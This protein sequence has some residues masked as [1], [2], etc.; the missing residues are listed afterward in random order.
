MNLLWKSSADLYSVTRVPIMLDIPPPVLNP[1]S[2][3]NGEV[4]Y[5]NYYGGGIRP[6]AV[7]SSELAALAD[8]AV[9]HDLRCDSLSLN[10]SKGN[11]TDYNEYH[12][13]QEIFHLI[14]MANCSLNANLSIAYNAT[15]QGEVTSSYSEEVHLA[16]GY[17]GQVDARPFP[18]LFSTYY[19]SPRG[20]RVSDISAVTNYFLEC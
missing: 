9:T 15:G 13:S 6:Y 3:L 20:A 10:S 19:E 11:A 1:I 4:D 8:Y 18:C 5:L 2:I 12:S 7:P 17:P 14:A 16:I